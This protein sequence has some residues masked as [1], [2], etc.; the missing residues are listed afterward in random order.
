MLR[1]S[2][3]LIALI[4]TV[5]FV[6]GQSSSSVTPEKTGNCNYCKHQD[7]MAGP[8]YSFDYCMETDKCFQ[9]VWNHPNAWCPTSWVSGYSLDLGENCKAIE[10]AE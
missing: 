2:Q 3:L 8:L 1:K 6:M 5:S 10:N 9:D 7:T 4:F